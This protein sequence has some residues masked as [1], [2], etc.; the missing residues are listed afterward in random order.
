[1]KRDLDFRTAICSEY[2]QLLEGCQ[3]A[4]VA[5]RER[6]E[7]IQRFGLEGERVGNEMRRLQADYAKSYTR[8]SQHP[9]DC[10][11]CCFTAGLSSNGRDSSRQVF[12]LPR[13]E[14]TA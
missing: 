3:H 14:V 4:L 12:I 8:L 1:M 7:E 9:K 13:R 10:A 6:S 5:W 11:I 2:E